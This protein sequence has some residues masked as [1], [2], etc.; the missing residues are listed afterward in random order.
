MNREELTKLIALHDKWV[1]T[2][3][4]CDWNSF[5]EYSLEIDVDWMERSVSKELFLNVEGVLSL[6]NAKE[7]SE[8]KNQ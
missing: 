1:K 3:D 7:K 8:I 2:G 4:F 5:N 6:L